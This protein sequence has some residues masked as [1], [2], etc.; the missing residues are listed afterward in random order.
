MAFGPLNMAF[1]PL[2]PPPL[3]RSFNNNALSNFWPMNSPL[4]N[5]A[6]L[7]LQMPTIPTQQMTGMPMTAMQL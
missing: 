2:A 1:D 5:P 4:Q 7:A 6:Y 3:V